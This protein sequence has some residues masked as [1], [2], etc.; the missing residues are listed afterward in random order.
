MELQLP[1]QEVL[2]LALEGEALTTGP[3]GSQRSVSKLVFGGQ[4]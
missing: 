1:K 2:P 4:L 3:P